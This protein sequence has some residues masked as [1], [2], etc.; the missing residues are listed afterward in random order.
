MPQIPGPFYAI[1]LRQGSYQIRIVNFITQPNS[2]LSTKTLPQ[3]QLV[4][5]Y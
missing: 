3:R 1:G 2:T 4:N 5:G